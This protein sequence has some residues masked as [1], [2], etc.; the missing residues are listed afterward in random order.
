MEKEYSI[1]VDDRIREDMGAMCNLSQG[2]RDD[3]NEKVIMNMYRKGYTLKQIAEIVEKSVEEVEAI[4]EKTEP[5][6]A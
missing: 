6:L 1:S 3:A 5:I 4:I 2:I